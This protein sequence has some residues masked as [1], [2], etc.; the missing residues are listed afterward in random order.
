[1]FC[2]TSVPC[3]SASIIDNWLD[4]PPD[5]RANSAVIAREG[6]RPLSPGWL[7]VQLMIPMACS[8]PSSCSF[9]SSKGPNKTKAILPINLIHHI[10]SRANKMIKLSYRND[11]S[12]RVS[13]W[14]NSFDIA[15]CEVPRASDKADR[16]HHRVHTP[17]T[18]S[19]GYGP[20]GSSLHVFPFTMYKNSTGQNNT[21]DGSHYLAIKDDK[22]FAIRMF[23][24]SPDMESAFKVKVRIGGVNV[25]QHTTTD[26]KQQSQDYFVVSEQKWVWG[27]QV[28]ETTARQFR[29]FGHSR[30]SSWAT[31]L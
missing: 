16:R 6:R 17:L 3:I 18:D 24:S 5:A 2:T 14:K 20:K 11:K 29:V 13:S 30:K 8:R 25:L 28:D 21:E 26:G 4:Q 19:D 7:F 22:A 31:I 23:S 27:K 9:S 1:M 10:S 15:F 12:V